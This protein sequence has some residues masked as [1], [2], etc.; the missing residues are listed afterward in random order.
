MPLLPFPFIQLF[1]PFFSVREENVNKQKNKS[2]Y[3]RPKIL[4]TKKVLYV[5]LPHFMV[6]PNAVEKL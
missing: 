2:N 3:I 6:S 5:R 1:C 4:Y